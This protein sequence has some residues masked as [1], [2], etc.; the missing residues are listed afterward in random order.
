MDSLPVTLANY[1]SGQGAQPLATVKDYQAYLSRLNQLGPWIDQ[2]IANMREG[3]Q[4]RRRAAEGDDGVGPAPV[5]AAGGRQARRQHLLHA[6]RS[7]ARPLLRR[8]QE[9]ADGRLPRHH[10]RQA[11]P[12]RWP[13]LAA[14]LENEYLPACRTSTGWSALPH[15]HGLVPGARG[16]P[17]HHRPA[18]GA[19]PPDRP[20]GSGAH[21]GASTRASA[22]RWATHGPAAGLPAWV[23]EQPKYKPFKTEDEDHRAS[24]ASSTPS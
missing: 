16:Q 8:R 21:P 24:T 5:Q 9:A 6:G 12:G 7:T 22:R 13:R 2:A 15:G 23:A 1:A 11:E 14:F 17:D 10:R 3:M 18:A 20:E 4:A 19:D